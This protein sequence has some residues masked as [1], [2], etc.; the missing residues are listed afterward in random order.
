MLYFPSLAVALALFTQAG[1]PAEPDPTAPSTV[2]DD[3]QAPIEDI[4]ITAKGSAR[5]ARAE[6]WTVLPSQRVKRSDARN[7]ADV[8]RR[9]PGAL[10]QTNSRGETLVFLRNAGER[11]VSVFY[12]G[13]PLEVPWDH[14]LDLK[15]IPATA[16]GRT[17]VA[18]GPLSNR[19]GPNISGGAIFLAPRQTAEYQ[20]TYLRSEVG[21][22]GLLKLESAVGLSPTESTSFVIAAEHT[23]YNGEPLVDELPFS[24][25]G[26]GLRT[27]TDTERTSALAHVAWSLDEVD[28]TATAFYG[29]AELGVAPE[30]HLDPA[31][32]QV[33]FWRYPNTELAMAII[34]VR[35]KGEVTALDAVVWGQAYDQ[36]IQSFASSRYD[37]LTQR[38]RDT[39]R[40]LGSRVRV[41]GELGPHRV[42]LGLYGSLAAHDERRVDAPETPA[43][44]AQED[45]FLNAFWSAGADYELTIGP[46]HARIGG[47]LDAL[48]PIETAGRPSSGAFRAWNATAGAKLD[49]AA[50]WS[51]H[52][53]IG[54]RARLPTPRELFGTALDRFILNEDLREERNTTIEAGVR[55]GGTWGS[56]EL[57]PFATWTDD[58]LAQRNVD[59]DG[60][61]L[62]Q[63]VNLDGS[64]V[65][66]VEVIGDVRVTQWMRAA[67]QV[68]ISD[69]R[70][71]GGGEDRLPERPSVQAFAELVFGE[72]T[73]L[74]VATEL[75]ARSDIYSLAPEGLRSVP[76]AAL[77]SFRAAYRLASEDWGQLETYVRLDNAFNTRLEPQLGLPEAGRLVRSGLIVEF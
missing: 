7:V 64:R 46:L 50:G 40:S 52:A 9:A 37:D 55:Y 36:S 30:S 5:A 12:D 8:L 59:V 21:A 26:D 22:G 48:E 1:R 72:D 18:R 61:T 39:N 11:Q 54:S 65:I 29:R 15:L 4:Q 56:V 62:R 20:K 25:P 63:R 41:A 51:L 19:Y 34:G 53:G 33:R 42:S 17:E 43:Q 60:A 35:A 3:D 76:G 69:V 44:T 68:L 13:A 38:Q 23:Q 28:L 71:L 45:A 66:G 14:R 47:G 32:E 6:T 73:G 31:E 2:Q 27:N 16:V 75:F 49:F 74:E 77:V 57:T 67:G 10:V 70:R 24:Q 58:T